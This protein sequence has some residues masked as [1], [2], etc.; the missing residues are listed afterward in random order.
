PGED[1]A[2]GLTG[3]GSSRRPRPRQAGP[4]L[5]AR[6]P[7]GG[8]TGLLRQA[9]FRGQNEGGTMSYCALTSPSTYR[10][11]TM[12]TTTRSAAVGGLALA[13]GLLAV[14]GP[15][16]A[17]PNKPPLPPGA[18]ARMGSDQFRHG[19]DVFFLRYALGGKA[20]VTAS[21]DQTLRLWDAAT[22]R[23][24][25]RFDLPGKVENPSGRLGPE[26]LQVIN[27]LGFVNNPNHNRLDKWPPPFFVAVSSGSSLGGV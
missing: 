11:F 10:G 2:G 24:L 14:V 25:R 19:R 13:A 7:A 18:V 12:I 8:T 23:E 6:T 1:S 5:G 3:G 4:P 20:L 17:E 21:K 9:S 26:P 27:E 15:G 22:G 16:R